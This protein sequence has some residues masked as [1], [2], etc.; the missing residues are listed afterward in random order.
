MENLFDLV[1]VDLQP[2][3]CNEFRIAFEGVE[4]VSVVD[5]RF[6][7]VEFD[8]IV[9]AAN[10][11]G[12]M[13]GGVDGAITMYFGNQMMNRV[14]NKII[15]DYHGEQPVGTSFIIRGNEEWNDRHNKYVAHTPTM[16]VPMN[17]RTT[18]NVYQAMKAMLLEVN[19]FNKLVDSGKMPEYVNRINTV[20]CTGL[21]TFCGEV[22][23][24][25]AAK[26][27][28]MAYNNFMN[29]PRAI[30]WEYAVERNKQ[31]FRSKIG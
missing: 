3:L 8:C 29:K 17:I 2:E 13:D 14:Q 6:E 28:R 31:I 16:R 27:M 11:F 15:E 9:S 10:S 23:F 22:P 7:D 30:S 24:N 26:D 12:L 20:A 18:E 1:L 25:K 5:G 21:G 19:N 4:K